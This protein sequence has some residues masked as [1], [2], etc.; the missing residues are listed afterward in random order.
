MTYAMKGIEQQDWTWLP[1]GAVGC[2]FWFFC[3]SGLSALLVWKCLMMRPIPSIYNEP[4]N[5]SQ[6]GFELES[7][8]EAELKNFQLRIDQAAARNHQVSNG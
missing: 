2:A 5:L 3:L 8:K 1:V 4:K 7:L 6:P